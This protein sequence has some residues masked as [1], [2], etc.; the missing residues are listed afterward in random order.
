MTTDFDPYADEEASLRRAPSLRFTI[1]LM[2]VL[3]LIGLGLLATAGF[4]RY[5]PI[6]VSTPQVDRCGSIA[7]PLALNDTGPAPLELREAACA[8]AIAQASGEAMMAASIG[9]AMLVALVI[10]VIVTIR[11]RARAN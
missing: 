1:S 9:V 3:G 2:V 11:R 10:V 5:Y 6:G 8:Q 4:L 7:E